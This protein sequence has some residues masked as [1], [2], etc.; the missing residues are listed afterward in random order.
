MMTEGKILKN[1]ALVKQALPGTL[2]ELQAKTLLP[3]GTIYRVLARIGA[4]RSRKAPKTGGVGRPGK[5]YS[6]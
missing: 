2:K 6:L 1:D 4:K 3:R 5:V